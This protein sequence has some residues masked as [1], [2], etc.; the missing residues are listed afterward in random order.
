MS[1]DWQ[2]VD[3]VVTLSLSTTIWFEEV[4]TWTSNTNIYRL[5]IR[6]TLKYKPSQ[7]S[8]WYTTSD[9]ESVCDLSPD[10][11]LRGIMPTARCLYP[12][13]REAKR[14][15]NTADRGPQGWDNRTRS[16]INLRPED[17][18]LQLVNNNYDNLYCVVIMLGVL[19]EFIAFMWWMQKQRQV[20]ADLD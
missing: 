5:V 3:L 4:L 17:G 9:P 7:L 11:L 1:E 13:P 10:L 15:I 14:D 6:P 12:G 20:A 19:R 18:Y 2:T 16:A 8:T